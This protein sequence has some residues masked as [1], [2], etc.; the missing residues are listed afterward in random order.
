MPAP[1]PSRAVELH[2]R[3][4]NIH[5][6]APAGISMFEALVSAACPYRV[7]LVEPHPTACRHSCLLQ[8]SK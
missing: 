3:P 4:L 6:F 8:P 5:A 1:Q 2:A 7:E